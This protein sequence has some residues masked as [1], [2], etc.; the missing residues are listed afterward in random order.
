MSKPVRNFRSL[1]KTLKGNTFMGPNDFKAYADDEET[2]RL[3]TGYNE[4]DDL[5][6]KRSK[7]LD[8]HK[9]GKMEQSKKK[10]KLQKMA[11]G[12]NTGTQGGSETE[13][14]SVQRSQE[15]TMSPPTH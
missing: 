1:K 14:E 4:Q 3:V 5:R 11:G 8:S 7:E 12:L 2:R 13:E 6:E 9:T 10:S 15:D